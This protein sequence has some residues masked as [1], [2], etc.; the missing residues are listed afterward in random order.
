MPGPLRVCPVAFRY[1]FLS[2]QRPEAF[3]LV[4]DEWIPG[5]AERAASR[6]ALMERI[7][8]RLEDTVSALD[9]LVAQERVE[10]FRPLTAGRLSV[11]KRLDRFR[12]AVGLLRGPFEARNG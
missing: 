2:E 8:A 9:G 5:P 12:H 10:A 1:A 6:R 3:A 7:A 4:G 11:N